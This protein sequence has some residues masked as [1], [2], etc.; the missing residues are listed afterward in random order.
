MIEQFAGL[1]Q[2]FL[3]LLYIRITKIDSVMETF[4]LPPKTSGFY[5]TDD[6]PP[7]EM[8]MAEVSRALDGLHS[9]PGI[10]KLESISY[11]Q[12]PNRNY[13]LAIVQANGEW[14]LVFVNKYYPIVACS[15]VL[16]EIALVK[17]GRKGEL[18][19]N[20][21]M[22]WPEIA[23]VLPQNWRIAPK[24]MLLTRI[25]PDE[26]LSTPMIENLQNRE[27]AEFSFYDPRYVGQIIFNNWKK[28]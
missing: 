24:S 21:Y 17:W 10:E 15:R 6:S 12:E 14:R 13:H 11:A 27:F 19:A 5:N 1:F 7:E 26:G 23:A 18:P 20:E 22:D 25:D 28:D 3:Y 2:I 9:L 4:A 16:D 8:P